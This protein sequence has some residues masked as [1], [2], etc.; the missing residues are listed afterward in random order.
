MRTVRLW[1]FMLVAVL[2]L[3]APASAHE[4][5]SATEWLLGDTAHHPGWYTPSPESQSQNVKLIGSVE[6][7]RFDST[8]RNSD[9]A[10]WGNRVYAGHYDGFQIVDASDPENPRQLVD[11]PC[12]GSQHDVSVWQRPAVRVGR[13]AALERRLRLRRASRPAS[14]ACGSSTSRTRARPS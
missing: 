12:P 13:D 8:Y 9:L 14:R 7:T 3:A 2:A 5:E 1:T 10:F 11:Y 6:R 4:S